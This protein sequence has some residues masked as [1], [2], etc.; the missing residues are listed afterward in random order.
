MHDRDVMALRA[1]YVP[2]PKL[3]N[4]R[5][6][7]RRDTSPTAR[8]GTRCFSSTCPKYFGKPC[9]IGQL[10]CV[11]CFNSMEYSP[12]SRAQA[13]VMRETDES[14]PIVPDIDSAISAAAITVVPVWEPVFVNS[15]VTIGYEESIRRSVFGKQNCASVQSSVSVSCGD[16]GTTSSQSECTYHKGDHGNKSECHTASHCPKASFR[17]RRSGIACLLTHMNDTLEG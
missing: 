9:N 4:D 7:T 2:L 5:M 11:S 8:A 17:H 3:K 14:V 6:T 1:T 13:Q 16:N 15:S 10:M 12:P